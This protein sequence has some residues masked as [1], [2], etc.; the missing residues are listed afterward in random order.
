[1]RKIRAF[2]LIL[3]LS[4]LFLISCDDED[5]PFINEVPIINE[6]IFS[7]NENSPSGTVV[8][9][10]LA[11][12]NNSTQDLSF[13]II[14]GNSNDVFNID[15]NTG[16]LYVNNVKYLDYETTPVFE[17]TIEVTDNYE[18]PLSISGK[19]TIN[20]LDIQPTNTGLISY[21]SF[22]NNVQDIFGENNGYG[23]NISYISG[24]PNKNNAVSFNG[25]DSYVSLHNEFDYETMTLSLWFNPHEITSEYG[26]VYTSDNPTLKY[27]LQNILV[28]KNDEGVNLLSVNVSGQNYNADLEEGE[29]YNITI[30]RNNKNYN[31]YLNGEIVQSGSFENYLTSQDGSSSAILGSL[32]TLDK[33]YFKGQID[34]VRI[35]NRELTKAEIKTIF[36]E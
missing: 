25:I 27:G 20:I 30:M 16:I 31:Y 22:E 12:D 9:T 5:N 28:L 19:I 6:Q 4:T 15:E 13:N 14:G 29:W 11:V 21:Y 34:D 3:G 33:N 36:Q 24:Y 2:L 23:I 8:D 1:M 35:Y 10:V 32:R 26:I 18:T 7:I 17:L